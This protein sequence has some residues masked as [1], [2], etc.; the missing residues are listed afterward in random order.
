M[1]PLHKQSQGQIRALS[2]A[3]NTHALAG[4]RPSHS[5]M[6]RLRKQLVARGK[7]E[8]SKARR[9]AVAVGRRERSVARR[10]L[11][12]EKFVKETLWK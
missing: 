7:S 12:V 1:W 6:Y 3:A 4:K 9:K 8:A 11:V 5:W 10:K 2:L